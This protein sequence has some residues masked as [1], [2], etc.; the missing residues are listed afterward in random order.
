MGRLTLGGLQS[1]GDGSRHDRRVYVWFEGGAGE[2][3]RQGGGALGGAALTG[4]H[5]R[6]GAQATTGHGLRHHAHPFTD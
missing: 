4:H 3:E 5:E 2:H 1:L 6:E